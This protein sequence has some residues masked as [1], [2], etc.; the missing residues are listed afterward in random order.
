M[1]TGIVY[2]YWGGFVKFTK[3]L[4]AKS[5]EI[6][7]NVMTMNRLNSAFY[8]QSALILGPALVS[9]LLCRQTPHGVL[10]FR[11]TETEIYC[12]EEDTACHAH[13]GKTPRNA[14][15]YREGGCAYVYLCYGIHSLLN[16]VTGERD[17]PEAILIRGVEG[18]DGPGR[19]TK[20]TDITRELNGED[21]CVSERLWLE[22]DGTN[23]VYDAFTRI[24]IGY[25]SAEDQARLWR[26]RA[27]SF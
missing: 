22:D 27:R 2:R 20:T 14:M 18:Y 23:P 16:V 15:L 8:R 19:L 26:F 1:M 21:L 5:A 25:A 3:F 9:K 10:R 17:H 24:G 6:R 4:I 11:I 13:R 12:G 7:Y